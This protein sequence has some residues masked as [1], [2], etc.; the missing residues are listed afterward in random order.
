M[1]IR[2]RIK[3]FNSSTVGVFFKQDPVCSQ[4]L[5]FDPSLMSVLGIE[6]RV[7]AILAHLSHDSSL[8]QVVRVKLVSSICILSLYDK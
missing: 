8:T 6:I 7:G 1:I 4:I 5:F 2:H 3:K